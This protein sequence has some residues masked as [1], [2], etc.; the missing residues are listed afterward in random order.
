M[1]RHKYKYKYRYLKISSSQ[2]SSRTLPFIKGTVIFLL[3]NFISPN[4]FYAVC[5]NIFITEVGMCQQRTM[6]PSCLV[7]RSAVF[8]VVVILATVP[9]LF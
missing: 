4:P 1:Y 6:V 5:L 9:V 2:F 8:L 3:L 7:P